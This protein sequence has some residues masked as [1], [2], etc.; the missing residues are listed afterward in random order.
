MSD[1]MKHI[2]VAYPTVEDGLD[3]ASHLGKAAL[4]IEDVARNVLIAHS[5]VAG[6]TGLGQVFPPNAVTGTGKVEFTAEEKAALEAFASMK[7]EDRAKIDW[8]A[9]LKVILPLILKLLGCVLVFAV[10]VGTAYAQQ[11]PRPPQAPMPPQATITELAGFPDA[12][13]DKAVDT[14]LLNQPQAPRPAPAPKK[15]SE[16]KECEN[17]APGT[18]TQA[19]VRKIR[20]PSV[21][22]RGLPTKFVSSGGYLDAYREAIRTGKP[23]ITWV[24]GNFCERCVAD[25]K[26]EFVHAF[27]DRWP[28]TGAKDTVDAPATVIG[29]PTGGIVA[30]VATVSRWIVGDD[31]FGHVPS[32][33][34]AIFNWR[35]GRRMT[36]DDGWSVQHF[37]DGSA[38]WPGGMA[39]AGSSGWSSGGGGMSMKSMGG[40]SGGGSMMRSAPMMRQAPMRTGGMKMSRGGCA[41][42][43]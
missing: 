31:T 11:A 10:L 33:R 34:R 9:F 2:P 14:F 13:I 21:D 28:E 7:A 42:G 12:Q 3:S 41:G 25:S 18:E 36:S 40:M 37:T 38:R 6:G 26:N 19:P 4:G 1:E 5:W 8:M 23:L 15:A 17:C 16:C 22:E 24:G 35:E 29:I 39:M 20:R 32:A 30:R 43:G 27:V